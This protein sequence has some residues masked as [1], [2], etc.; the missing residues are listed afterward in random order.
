MPRHVKSFG[1]ALARSNKPVQ[2]A[3]PVQGADGL[4]D[5]VTGMSQ[6]ALKNERVGIGTPRDQRMYTTYQ[7]VAPQHRGAPR[8]HLSGTRGSGVA[9]LAPCLRTW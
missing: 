3:I 6:M 8:E 4:S 9:S 1:A 2:D 7:T 5:F